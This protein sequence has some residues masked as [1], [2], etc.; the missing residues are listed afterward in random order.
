MDLVSGETVAC[1]VAYWFEASLLDGA[2]YERANFGELCS[3][4]DHPQCAVEG[5]LYG[6]AH[7]L[8][9]VVEVNSDGSVGDVAVKL[10]S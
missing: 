1:E 3:G 6:E 2:F 5:F 4:L 7:G 9:L 8:E 10:R